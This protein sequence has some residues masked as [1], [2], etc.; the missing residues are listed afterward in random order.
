LEQIDRLSRLNADDWER[1]KS[2]I[3]A[4]R[5]RVVALD[6]PTSHSF[7]KADTDAFT[8]RMLEAVN[9]MMMDVLAAVARKDYE[10]RR[11]RQA[12]GIARIKAD[13]ALRVKRY[14]GRKADHKRNAA[15]AELLARG[16]SWSKIIELTKC[17]R[18]T[19][20]KL[21]REAREAQPAA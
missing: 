14:A 19:L 17:S 8:T 5:V 12:Q 11:R 15:I 6:L 10:D 18:S 16:T 9:G 1:L 7:A 3:A 2:E 21:A 13:E 4:R 20:A